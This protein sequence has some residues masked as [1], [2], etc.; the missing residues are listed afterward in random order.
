VTAERD[1]VTAERD[2]VTAERDA[3]TAE[4]EQI[5]SSNSWQITKPLR[6]MGS[7]FRSS[8]RET[9]NPGNLEE[10]KWQANWQAVQ[11]FQ[12]PNSRKTHRVSDHLTNI[13]G[14]NT[15]TWL[16]W[17]RIRKLGVRVHSGGSGDIIRQEKVSDTYSLR[18]SM[19]KPGRFSNIT[20]HG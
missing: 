13:E 19:Q 11:N 6:K 8:K 14:R 17:L 16:D 9:S 3:V 5:L 2:A 10:S 1:A 20:H 15:K 18:N 7:I 12:V 4:R